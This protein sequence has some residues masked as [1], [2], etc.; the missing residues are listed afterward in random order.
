MNLERVWVIGDIRLGD[1]RITTKDAKLVRRYRTYPEQVFEAL[2][3]CVRKDDVIVFMGHTV[4][5]KERLWWSRIKEVP[6]SKVAMLGPLERK[7]KQWYEKWVDLAATMKEVFY[8]NPPTGYSGMGHIQLS[9]LPAFPTVLT[10]PNDYKYADICR[11]FE[12]WYSD[13]S[14]SYNLHAHTLGLGAEDHRTFDCGIDV[15]GYQPKLLTQVLQLAG[16]KQ[17]QKNDNREETDLGSTSQS[18]V[19]PVSSSTSE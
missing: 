4:V 15:I 12:K 17:E 13:H 16:F 19:L 9:H 5:G 1:D 18:R 7:P 11:R 8:V 3:N 2:H 6:G 10:N 14:C